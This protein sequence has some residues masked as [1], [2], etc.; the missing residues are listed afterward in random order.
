[1]LLPSE[2][3]N[4][5]VADSEATNIVVAERSDQYIVFEEPS[6]QY[7]C[8]RTKRP[9]LLLPRCSWGRSATNIVAAS[10]LRSSWVAPRGLWKKRLTRSS[11]QR[12]HERDEESIEEPP[13]DH[14]EYYCWYE[15]LVKEWLGEV[16]DDLHHTKP[17]WFTED[18]IKRIPLDFYLS[19]RKHTERN[20]RGGATE[21]NQ[22]EEHRRY[23]WSGSRSGHDDEQLGNNKANTALFVNRANPFLRAK[24]AAQR[25]AFVIPELVACSSPIISPKSER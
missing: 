6:D 23:R 11:Q 24:S 5:I 3:T 19:H 4:I 10:L 8:C 16:W 13:R 15:D 9:I 21:E 7:C 25:N 18:A 1:M 12:A 14:R 2:A 17:A 22:E 20:W